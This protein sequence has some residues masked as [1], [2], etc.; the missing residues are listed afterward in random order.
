MNLT[1]V[2]FDVDNDDRLWT[3][4]DV[5]GYLGVS[6]RQVWRLLKRGDLPRPIR[7]GGTTRCNPTA[8]R[9]HLGTMQEEPAP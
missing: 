4:D 5:A 6:N 1:N 8:I 9:Q 7:L 2:K 3:V